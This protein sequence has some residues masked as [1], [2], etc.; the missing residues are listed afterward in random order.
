MLFSDY[1]VLVTSRAYAW[2]P[3]LRIT[4]SVFVSLCSVQKIL[5]NYIYP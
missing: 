3:A 1:T 5:E 2:F 4:S